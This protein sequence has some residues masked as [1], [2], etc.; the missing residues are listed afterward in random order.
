MANE[1]ERTGPGTGPVKEGLEG[2]IFEEGEP[3]SSGKGDTGAGSEAA[4]GIH[5]AASPSEGAPGQEGTG[6]A[7]RPGSEPLHQREHEHRSGYGGE[8]GEP[9]TSS[10]QRE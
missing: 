8:G 1:R 6:K 5:G 4:E 3:A 9:R 7:G 10:D 2:A